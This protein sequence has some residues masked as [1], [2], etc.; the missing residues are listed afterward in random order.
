MEKEKLPAI[1]TA[2]DIAGYL[3]ISRRRVYEFL[4]LEPE[5]GGIRH[6]KFGASKRIERSDFIDW[7][8]N[9]K[10]GGKSK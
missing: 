4:L 7:V 6:A 3:K 10:T 9:Q 1:L 8:E 5:Q 2:A